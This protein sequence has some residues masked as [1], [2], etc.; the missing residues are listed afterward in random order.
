M[1]D[2]LMLPTDI[3]E[4]R[5]RLAEAT[6]TLRAIRAGEVD[7]VIV[8]GEAGDQVYTLRSAEQPYRTLVEQMRE[9]A[10][11][12]SVDGDILYC[13]HRFGELVALP[14]EEVIGGSV[15]RFLDAAARDA[16]AA[17][18]R[19]GGGTYRGRLIAHDG[20]P[21]D[22]YLSLTVAVAAGIE[23]RSL[24]VTDLSELVGAHADRDR[25][26]RENRAKDEFIAMLAHELRNPLGAIAGA[27]QVL[28]VAGRESEP[29]ARARGVITRQVHHLS[30]LI[31]DLLDVG[32]LAT[33]KIV[34][35]RQPVDLADVVRRTVGVLAAGGRL[36]KRLEVATEPIW[37][38]ADPTR[39]EQI[40][41]NLIG[42]AV[43]YTEGGGL[44]R[45][46]VT[47]EGQD[48]RLRIQDDGVGIRGDLLPRIFDLF[49]QDEQT[50]DRAQGGLGIGL[51]LV[52]RLVELHGGVVSAASD[53]PGRGS[54]FTVKFRSIPAPAVAGPDAT[55]SGETVKRR[56][57]V[58]EDNADSRDMYRVA[59]ELAGH[60]VFEAEDAARGL[61]MLKS[62]HPDI[63]LIDIGLPGLDGYELARRFR[64]EA[65][66]HNV[67]LVALTGYGAS[68]DRDRSR[69]AGFDHHLTKPVSQDTLREL[70]RGELGRIQSSSTSL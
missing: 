1:P 7:A 40:I 3:A 48:A 68:D 5:A 43:K 66:G 17:L 10:A 56:V 50:L 11:I 63:A 57:L 59:L 32:R 23:R 39:I 24:I 35:T 14:L 47:A 45:V 42:N 22:V 69:Q 36:D 8:H 4:L 12:L 55:P 51:T 58:V 46:S 18:V 37:I 44:I 19:A 38:D 34:L 54:A 67:L 9:G 49:V 60:K 21:L 6:E 15:E 33:G 29:A 70:L 27:V 28:D 25:A 30:R 16:F 53:G 26:Q 64:A 20:Q 41:G 13:N 2:E 52:R 61:E 65:S 62:E 31:D